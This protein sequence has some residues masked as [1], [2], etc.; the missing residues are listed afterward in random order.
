MRGGDESKMLINYE[1]TL[2][3]L[4]PVVSAGSG[5]RGGSEGITVGWTTSK[6]AKLQAARAVKRN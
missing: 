5:A 2:K 4:V 6:V 1:E 3:N